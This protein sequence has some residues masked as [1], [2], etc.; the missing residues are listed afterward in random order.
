MASIFKQIIERVTIVR[1]GNAHVASVTS[2]PGGNPLGSPPAIGDS[3]NPAR[4]PNPYAGGSG[5]MDGGTPQ[6]EVG[7]AARHVILPPHRPPDS[8]QPEGS[9]NRP[10]SFTRTNDEVWFSGMRGQGTPDVLW[11]HHRRQALNGYASLK[12]YGSSDVASG[13]EGTLV[14][15]PPKLPRPGHH[16]RSVAG[17]KRA[18]VLLNY[19]DSHVQT[20]NVPVVP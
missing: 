12:A 10:I 5:W 7:D 6:V 17:A 2:S 14:L 13:P 20:P 1:D 9:I 16:A 4:T 8:I 19:A 11:H 18:N 3:L 15:Y